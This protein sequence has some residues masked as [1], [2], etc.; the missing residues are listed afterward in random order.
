M[1]MNAKVSLDASERRIRV[2]ERVVE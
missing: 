2:L 1:P